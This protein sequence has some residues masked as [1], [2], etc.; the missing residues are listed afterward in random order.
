MRI[1]EHHDGSITVSG[2]RRPPP[3]PP[4]YEKYEGDPY[5]FFPILADCE[6]RTVKIKE[7]RCCGDREHSFCTRDG[8]FIL[9]SDCQR[10]LKG[11]GQSPIDAS[12]P[13]KDADLYQALYD[14][15]TLH[16]GSAKHNRCPGVRYLP[17]YLAHL[18]S[19]I[20]DLGC[21]TGDTI[22]ALQEKGFVAQGMD[23][24]D[25]GLN[26]EVAD[27]TKPQDLSIYETAICIDV[28]EHITDDKLMGLI[29]NLQQVMHQVVTVHCASSRERGY[30]QELHTNIKTQ[31]EWVEFLVQHFEVD[32]VITLAPHR[33]MYL[34]RRKHEEA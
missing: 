25:R 34:M 13:L 6:H 17:K 24:I 8:K 28:L 31:K 2:V 27:I 26:H 19:P 10:C 14:D 29:Q 18:I 30:P 1:R 32:D 33:F 16:Y 11:S 7:S 22:R 5:R 20:I 9:R 3:P 15:A 21:G 12:P 23:W 4:G